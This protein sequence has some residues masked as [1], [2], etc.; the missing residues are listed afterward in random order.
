MSDTEALTIPRLRVNLGAGARNAWAPMRP[1]RRQKAVFILEG[2]A[3]EDRVG[4][5]GAGSVGRWGQS[6]D[7]RA[8]DWI[9]AASCSP[10]RDL[11]PLAGARARSTEAGTRP[12]CSRRP[13]NPSARIGRSSTPWGPACA[14]NLDPGGAPRRP[15]DAA[16]ALFA[17]PLASKRQATQLQ[18]VWLIRFNTCRADPNPCDA[19]P[20][21]SASPFSW[22]E[23]WESARRA[24]KTRSGLRFAAGSG[25]Q[26]RGP[27][28]A[29]IS[30]GRDLNSG[31]GAFFS[32]NAASVV[33]TVVG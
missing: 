1:A 12:A 31:L 14:C 22:I 24:L 2:V 15:V 33:P 30:A 13:C 8:L 28:E 29:M 25:K 9:Q 6:I 5:E 18:Q 11:L 20:V 16:C 32:L 27:I 10:L 23:F 4:T 19:I 3:V 7:A 26:R 17:S 21:T